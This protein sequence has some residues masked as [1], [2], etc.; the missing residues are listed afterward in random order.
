[1]FPT[2]LKPGNGVSHSL[3]VIGSFTRSCANVPAARAAI[4]SNATTKDL[5][6]IS[7]LLDFVIWREA[8]MYEYTSD[9]RRVS[10]EADCQ[11][12]DVFNRCRRSGDVDLIFSRGSGTRR[13]WYTG[14]ATRWYDSANG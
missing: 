10:N 6:F 2:I 12:L 14:L 9:S 8:R 7:V 4:V 3:L 13:W 11:K 5:T 1:M